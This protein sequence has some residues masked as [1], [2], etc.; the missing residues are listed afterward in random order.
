[1]RVGHQL[2]DVGV[3]GPVVEGPTAGEVHG[4]RAQAGRGGHAE[5]HPA[6]VAVQE[7]LVQGGAAGIREDLGGDEA[8]EIACR[9]DMS[10][11]SSG[12][13]VFLFLPNGR[14]EWRTRVK[15]DLR[16]WYSKNCRSSLT[17]AI[18]GT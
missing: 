5:Q 16:S 9:I 18:Q 15:A 7:E 13:R 8:E 14:K 1:M 10:N 4:D 3:A 6:L 17:L 2:L 11:D 12:V